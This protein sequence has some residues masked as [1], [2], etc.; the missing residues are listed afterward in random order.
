[1]TVTVMKYFVPKQSVKLIN[2]RDYKHLDNNIFRYGLQPA[3]SVLDDDPDYNSFEITFMEKLNKHSPTKEKYVCANN[4]P[5]MNKVLSKAIMNRLHLRNR[6]LKN[7]N[8]M[9]ELNYKRQRNFVVNLMR[10]E[11]KKYYE[12]IDPHKICNCKK[13][14]KTI[15]SLSSD[16]N[17]ISEKITLIE[18]NNIISEDNEVA[19]IMNDFFTNVVTNLNIQGYTHPELDSEEEDHYTQHHK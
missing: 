13:F 6:Y 4:A 12:N 1:M 18:G 8:S 14:W 2:Y 10:R 7:P 3:L 16:K 19:E 5:F 11:K 15:K 9:T 17:N